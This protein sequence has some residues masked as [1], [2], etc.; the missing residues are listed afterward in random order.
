MSYSALFDTATA[1]RN[2]LAIEGM[3]DMDKS[4]F[5]VGAPIRKEMGNKQIALFPF[6][7]EVNA[8]LRNTQRSANQFNPPL[9]PMNAVRVLP[10]DIQFL[11]TVFAAANASG[12]DLPNE[13]TLLGRMIQRLESEPRLVVQSANDAAIQLQEQVV[14]LT[15]EYY[16]MEELSRIWSLF[17][18][19]HYRTSVVYTASPVS[20]EANAKAAGRPVL[21]SQRRQGLLYPSRK[22]GA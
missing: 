20:I 6:H 2:H 1:L 9:S 15:P 17:P 3:D 5:H 13:L 7:L 22:G 8:E 4:N 21:E 12:N 14:T 16:P 11:I 18:Q 19:E 10:L